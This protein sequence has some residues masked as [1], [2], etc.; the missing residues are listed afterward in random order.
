MEAIVFKFSTLELILL[1]CS[2]TLWLIQLIYY[3]ALYN[4]LYKHQVAVRKGKVRFSEELPPLSVVIYIKDSRERVLHEFLLPVLEQDYPK[5]EV[6]VVNDAPDHGE[7]LLL[8]MQ[9]QYPH[10]HYTFIPTSARY[11]SRKK[12]ALTLGAK[13]GKYEWLVF[14]EANCYPADKNWLRLMAR[15]FTSGTQVVLGYSNFQYKNGWSHKYRSFDLLFTSLRYLGFALADK[16]YMGIGR[17]MAYRKELFFNQKGFSSHL[18]LNRGDDDLFI[19]QIATKTNTCVELDAGAVIRM[20]PL[21]FEEDWGEEK[22]TYTV[23][24]KYFRG[25]QRLL[26]GFETLSRLL[27]HIVFTGVM[28][29]FLL[30]HYWSAAGV[31]ALL[32][33]IRYIVQA[34]VIN[35]TSVELGEK[36]R[37]Y[38]TLPIFDILLPLQTLKYKI[39]R[40]YRGK[41][42]FMKRN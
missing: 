17:N 18:D 40:D 36:R 22:M 8:L 6:I 3:F 23:T 20:Q 38:F 7:E 10:L 13:A 1:S 30:N 34:V 19:N 35:R 5:F 28:V 4:R 11:I 21:A 41:N 27:F 15:N 31:A 29:F 14:T 32:W 33:L 37:Y 39:Y 12:L 2:G 25:S 16:P 24:S 9:K 42:Y 26:L